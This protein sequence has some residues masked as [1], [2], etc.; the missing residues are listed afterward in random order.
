MRPISLEGQ[1]LSMQEWE[2]FR[3]RPASAPNSIEWLGFLQPLKGVP[4][5][6]VSVKYTL[7]FHP[8]VNVLDPSLKKGA[9]HLNCDMSLCLYYHNDPGELRWTPDK[10]IS[11]TII[12]WTCFWL[13]CYVYWIY[14]GNWSGPEAPHGIN[15]GDPIR[16]FRNVRRR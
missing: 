6:T 4:K 1:I 16:R 7:G 12:P 13:A 11:E 2:Q 10:A 14:T 15:K 8:K 5:F 3:P 9:P